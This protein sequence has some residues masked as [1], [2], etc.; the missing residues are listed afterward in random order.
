MCI[1]QAAT[2]LDFHRIFQQILCSQGR[3]YAPPP[4]QYDGER[5][6]MKILPALAAAC[7]FVLSAHAQTPPVKETADTFSHIPEAFRRA[8]WT[9]PKDEWCYD[10]VNIFAQFRHSFWID[11]VPEKATLY[12]T[13]D[14]CYRLY[15]NG[16]YVN[17]GPARGYQKSW[18]YDEIDVAKYLRPDK[19]V[20][21]VRVYNAGRSTFGYLSQGTAGVIFALDLGG[22]NVIASG[23]NTPSRIQTGC[24]RLTAWQSMQLN[25]QEHIDLREEDP[26]WTALDYDD[27]GWVRGSWSAPFNRMPFYDFE[28]RGIPLLEEYELPPAKLIA[29]GSGKAVSQDEHYFNINEL[30]AREGMD[31]SAV[32]SA[33]GAVKVPPSKDGE[34]QSFI[35]DFGH[36]VVGM[37]IMKVEGAKGGEIIDLS[38]F[39]TMH[40][41]FAIDNSYR[42]HCKTSL[43]N[44]M[45]CRPGDQKHDFFQISGIRYLLV[46]VRNNPDSEIRIT[47][48]LRWS[49]YPMKD[50]GK[51]S[52]S[53]PVAN[54]IWEACKLTQKVCSLDAYVDT[55]MR[56]Q[57]QWWGDARVQA[58]NTFFISGDDRLLRRGIRIISMQTTPNGLTYGHAPTMAHHCILP[59]FSLIWI[60]TLWDHY[61]QTGSPE[62]YSAHKDTVSGILSYF[63]GITDPETGL[64][65]ADNRYWLFLDWTDIQKDGQPAVLN[66]WLLYA[67]DRMEALCRDA[68]MKTDA[69]KFAARAK[70]VRAAIEKNL[71]DTDGLVS[72]G[73]RPDGTMNPQKSIHAQTLAKMN[74]I[75]GFDFEKAKELIFLPYLRDGKLTHGYPSSYWVVYVLQTMADAG[76]EREVYDYI[77]KNWAAMSEYGTV[78]EGFNF[79]DGSR[80]HAWTAHPSFLLPRILGGVRQEAPGWKKVSFKPNYFEDSAEV[81]YP[82]PQ[83]SIK[84]AWKKN[85]DGSVEESLETPPTVEVVK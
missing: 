40:E 43:S 12:I 59:D 76:Y 71:V 2:N 79:F 54:R 49:A 52:S 67:L 63:D 27:S 37:P 80:S 38:G 24:H 36:M 22:G 70:K 84:V 77:L 50:E 62:A 3:R 58:W 19:N 53:N 64:A 55:P 10:I 75:K 31:H 35:F 34:F 73:I 11:S 28:G 81:T 51:F 61:W 65:K 25:N 39:D 1:P 44:R 83:G 85:A 56:E 78:F 47:P 13:A 23:G 17:S 30:V 68:G 41:N 57:A 32:P 46:R 14:Q 8:H 60:L 82:T 15:I 20:I 9:W 5:L 74:N 45:I 48:S 16:E 42:H 6:F 69:K 29:Q 72:D 7:A 18:P 4:T 21:A 26:G 33:G 66:L